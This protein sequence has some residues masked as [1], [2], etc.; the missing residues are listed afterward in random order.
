RVTPVTPGIRILG[1]GLSPAGGLWLA[2]RDTAVPSQLMGQSLDSAA[3]FGWGGSGVLIANVTP[4]HVDF[5]PA[6]NG[7]VFMTWDGND[8]SCAR[9]SASG[10]KLWSEPNGRQLVATA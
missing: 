4:T 10:A 9:L 1:S 2:W 3:V 6:A 7:D 8:I 5:V